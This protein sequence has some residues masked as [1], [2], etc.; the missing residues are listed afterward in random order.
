MF[1]DHENV[2]TNEANYTTSDIIAALIVRHVLVTD[3]TEPHAE[4]IKRRVVQAHADASDIVRL[5]TEREPNPLLAGHVVELWSAAVTGALDYGA[6]I[7]DVTARD[8]W[9]VAIVVA[10]ER[11]I[12]AVMEHANMETR[13]VS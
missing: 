13:V 5:F 4:G 3:V 1:D 2:L 7:K 8:E 9:N 12:A 10:S 11:I 6:T